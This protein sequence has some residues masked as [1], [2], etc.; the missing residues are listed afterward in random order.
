MQDEKQVR[1]WN[2]FALRGRSLT[3]LTKRGRWLKWSKCHSS[4]PFF[5]P[6]EGGKFKMMI[7]TDKMLILSF[8]CI[9]KINL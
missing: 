9:N 7:G 5:A 1:V 2:A 3:T 4:E 8:F 6:E